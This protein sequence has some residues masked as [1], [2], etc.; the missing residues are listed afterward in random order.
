MASPESE[1]LQMVGD[2]ECLEDT[3]GECT[4][5][6]QRSG[7][8]PSGNKRKRSVE[9]EIEM[10]DLPECVTARQKGGKLG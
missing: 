5:R 9:A 10:I 3:L 2:I 1:L 4:Y 8:G 7:Q 6:G